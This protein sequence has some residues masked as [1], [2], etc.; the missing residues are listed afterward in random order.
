[1]P[2]LQNIAHALAAGLVVVSFTFFREP[3]SLAAPDRAP[4]TEPIPASI[5]REVTG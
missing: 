3:V 2:S 5:P 1:M 4:V